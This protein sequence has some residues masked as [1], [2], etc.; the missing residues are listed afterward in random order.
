MAS[1]SVPPLE[2]WL[3]FLLSTASDNAIIVLDPGGKIVQ[4]LGGAERRFG[5]TQ[6]EALGLDFGALFTSEDRERG[7]DR[8]EMAIAAASKRS[9]DDRWHVRR[10][11]SRFWGS[12]LLEV[13][14]NED[15]SVWGYCKVL[16]DRTD[17]RTQLDSLQNRLAAGEEEGTRRKEFFASLGHEMRNVLSSMQNATTVIS[18]S[19]NEATR[20]KAA[21]VLERQLISVGRLLDDLDG[22][23]EAADSRPRLRLG[24]LVLQEALELAAEDIRTQV[25]QK[26]QQLVVTVPPVPIPIHAD[27]DRLQQ[28]LLNL[29]SNASKYTHAGG[30][31]HLTAT[32]EASEAVVRITDDGMGISHEVLPHIFELF[33]RG[34]PAGDVPGSGVGLAVVK[35]LATLHGGGVEARSPGEGKGSVFTLRLPIG[36]P[37][38]SDHAS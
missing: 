1:S 6:Q 14:L 29:L 34:A 25:E 22:S 13:V 17:L 27:P 15:G 12:G 3:N 20:S 23:L 35:E 36:G 37:R 7:L 8:Q 24:P 19:T 18:A 9:E 33:T 21:Q 5:Y 2:T 11:G 4:W 32:V 26:R 10:D 28:M 16:R 31:I 30:H 38:L